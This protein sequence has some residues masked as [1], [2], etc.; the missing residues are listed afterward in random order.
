MRS[1][2]DQS[3]PHLS[4]L[5]SRPPH[6]YD[7]I[8]GITQVEPREVERFEEGI[9]QEFQDAEEVRTGRN[10]RRIGDRRLMGLRLFH[11]GIRQCYLTGV[12][13]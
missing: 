4:L 7:E 9:E 6:E 2:R 8:M 10:W 1:V 11:G 3:R 12:F 13:R 5:A